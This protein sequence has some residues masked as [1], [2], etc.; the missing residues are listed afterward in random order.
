MNFMDI[1]EIMQMSSL[2]K[3]IMS[4]NFEDHSSSTSKIELSQSWGFTGSQKSA[5]NNS[6]PAVT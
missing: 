1:E 6:C 5:A 3:H 2:A 4:H